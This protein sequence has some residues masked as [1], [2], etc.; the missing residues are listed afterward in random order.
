MINYDVVSGL[1]KLPCCPFWL[2]VSLLKPNSRKGVPLVKG[3]LENLCI[4]LGCRIW[5]SGLWAQGCGLALGFSAFRISA[6]RVSKSIMV[7]Y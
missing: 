4:T 5:G 6:C 1:K 7:S 2:G 3:L